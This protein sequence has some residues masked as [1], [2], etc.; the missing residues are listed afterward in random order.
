MGTDTAECTNMSTDVKCSFR[1]IY[2]VPKE[3]GAITP[4]LHKDVEA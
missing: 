3:M 1:C 4:Y 2:T